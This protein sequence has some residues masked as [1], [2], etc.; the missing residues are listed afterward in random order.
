MRGPAGDEELVDDVAEPAPAHRRGDL[1]DRP[2][3]PTR[4]QSVDQAHVDGRQVVD[5]VHHGAGDARMSTMGNR[6]G[7]RLP[8][9]KVIAQAVEAQR[10][11]MADRRSAPDG[12]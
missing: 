2:V 8:R 12:E 6:E 5:L 1:Y 11:L 7:Q 10:R 9:D 4:W 3:R